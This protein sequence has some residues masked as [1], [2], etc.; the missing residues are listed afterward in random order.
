MITKDDFKNYRN[1]TSADDDTKITLIVNAV[2]EF[3]K[4][5]VGRAIEQETV[6]EYFDGDDINGTIFLSN[7]PLIS[8][9]SIQ[10]NQGTYSSPDWQD[11]DADD[12]QY[13]MEIGEIL[14]D[15]MYSGRRNIK[16]VYVAGYITAN[17]PNSLKVAALKL[18]SKIY[19]KGESEGF[20][21]EEVAGAS[22]QWGKFLSDDIKA[23]LDAA[24]RLKI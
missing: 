23:L 14:I 6:T 9:T 15:K 10:F 20:S 1:I 11:F 2:K 19:D 8:L 17:I 13:D 12:Y 5:Y 22:I 16:V 21:N 4:S 18:C 3:V 24:K 7:L